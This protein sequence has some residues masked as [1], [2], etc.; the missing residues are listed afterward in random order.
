MAFFYVENLS[1]TEVAEAMK[2]SEGA[3]KFHLHQ[4]RDRLRGV[5][6]AQQETQP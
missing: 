2:L 6:T 4:G 3:V 1:I 5:F